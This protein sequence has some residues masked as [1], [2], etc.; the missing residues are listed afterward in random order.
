MPEP[1]PSKE[2]LIQCFTKVK[3]GTKKRDQRETALSK[4]SQPQKINEQL[5]DLLR[6]YKPKRIKMEG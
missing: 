3:A 4:R 5:D 1:S 6:D 2:D